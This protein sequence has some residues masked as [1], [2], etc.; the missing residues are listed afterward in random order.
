MK[1][2]KLLLTS[3]IL[4]PAV[5][6]P[7]L[8]TTSCSVYNQ[9]INGYKPSFEPYKEKESLTD[10][11]ANQLW[12]S[13]IDD[14]KL[15]EE[16]YASCGELAKIKIK[17]EY[18]ESG[19]ESES[20]F[21]SFLVHWNY[22]HIDQ[23]NHTVSYKIAGEVD[24]VTD[25]TYEEQLKATSK[26]H[27]S[28]NFEIKNLEY[29]IAYPDPTST[30]DLTWCFLPKKLILAPTIWTTELTGSEEIT[31][32]NKYTSEIHSVDNKLQYSIQTTE[33]AIINEHCPL[34]V[35]LSW[36]IDILVVN[37]SYYLSECKYTP[38][39]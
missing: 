20:K 18:Y 32:N 31:F 30:Y 17:E 24:T 14:A 4:A 34:T 10:D 36:M 29:V 39:K 37:W 1:K 13:F 21:T 23:T 5:I 2:S 26:D 8:L 9:L 28:F 12:F 6:V 15:R 27:Y 33:G 35:D 19:A 11:E 25:Y 3:G 38:S 7:T 16:F 22:G